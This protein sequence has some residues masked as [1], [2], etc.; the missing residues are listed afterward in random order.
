MD[1][2]NTNYTAPQLQ[3]HYI[4][5]TTTAAVHHTTSSSCGW[6]DH[7]NHCNHSK[8]HNSNHLS[9]HQLIRSAIR[10]SQQPTSPIGFLFWNLRHHLVRYYWYLFSDHDMP[11]HPAGVQRKQLRKLMWNCRWSWGK[12]DQTSTSTTSVLEV[13]GQVIMANQTHQEIPEVHSKHA[14]SCCSPMPTWSHT[15]NFHHFD[16]TWFLHTASGKYQIWAETWGVEEIVWITWRGIRRHGPIY[17]EVFEHQA[18]PMFTK[19]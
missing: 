2:T 18:A 19:K 11:H 6:G 5:T 10:D 12:T 7:C 8:K 16:T 1:Y 17:C 13:F 14:L 9:V 3:L 4:T 15:W